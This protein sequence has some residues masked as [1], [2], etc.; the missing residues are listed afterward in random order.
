MSFRP[1]AEPK[2][3][4]A[5]R[6]LVRML[7]AQ[8]RVE[9]RS[10]VLL[11]L[12]RD[13]GDSWYPMYIKLLVVVGESAPTSAQ[14]LLAEALAHGLQHG[15]TAGG[16]LGSWGVPVQL[17]AALAVAG[18]GFL[19]MSAARVLDPLAYLT[20]WF[21]QS[22][23]RQPLPAEVFEK[24]VAAVLSLFDS[25]PPA[26]A[27]YQAKL[28]ADVASSAEGAYSATSL[29]RLGALVEAWSAGQAPHR[30]AATVARSELRPP[31]LNSLT[32][33]TGRSV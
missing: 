20:V 29:L 5:A 32:R 24:S 7:Q 19:R 31:T 13:L 15:Q 18:Q 23:S 10:Q 3:G 11:K 2:F 8:P 9:D 30:V 16:T 17:P 4:L 12:N 21:S 27:I 25:S 22:T 33:F 26:R 6:S 1:F 28:R 14:T